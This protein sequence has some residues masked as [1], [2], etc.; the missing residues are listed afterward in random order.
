MPSLQSKQKRFQLTWRPRSLESLRAHSSTSFMINTQHSKSVGSPLVLSSTEEGVIVEHIITVSEWGFPF[1]KTDLRHLV[2]HYLDKCERKVLQL[3]DNLP[4][5][6]WA[7]RFLE[8]HKKETSEKICQNLKRSKAQLKAEDFKIYFDNLKA[9]LTQKD[10]SLVPPHRIFN[11]DETNLS[12]DPGV[13]KCIFKR[14]T[15]YPERIMDSSKSSTSVMYCGS[16]SGQV[17]PPYVVYKS[18]HLYASWMVGG[19]PHTRYNRS[20]SGW[21]DGVIFK[22][23]FIQM[24]LPYVKKHKLNEEGKVVLLGDNLSSHFSSEVL[25]LCRDNNIAFVCLPKNST[26][27]TQPLDVAFYRPLKTE[28]WK[29]KQRKFQTVT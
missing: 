9:T 5:L 25:Q 7:A 3:K 14:G 19:P 18:T 1:S 29:I 2:K 27:L 23:W 11:F 13:K 16:A 10:G 12:D 17:L 26:H 4:T 22:D 21:F 6:Q 28:N 15:K 24:F 8:R 20:K